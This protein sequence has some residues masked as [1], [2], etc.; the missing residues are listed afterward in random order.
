MKFKLNLSAKYRSSDLRSQR[1]KKIDK[2]LAK[3]FAASNLPFKTNF[4]AKFNKIPIF[5]TLK[6][7]LNEF[8]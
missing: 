2:I 7:T 3:S 4:D 6:A 5:Y 8:L 1:Q